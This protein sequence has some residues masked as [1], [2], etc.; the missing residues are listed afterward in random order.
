MLGIIVNSVQPWARSH[1]GTGS[2]PPS[3]KGWQRK[4]LFPPSQIPWSAP[5]FSIAS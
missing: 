1:H 2:A 3:E 5:Y 4:I